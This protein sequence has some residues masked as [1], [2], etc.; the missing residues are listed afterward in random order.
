MADSGIGE[1]AEAGFPADGAGDLIEE[2]GTNFG[3]GGGGA[4]EKISGD[5]HGGRKNFGILKSES[6]SCA[7]GLHEGG[8]VGASDFEGNGSFNAGGLGGGLG[9]GKFL[10]GT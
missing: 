8:V 9:G 2:A 10:G 5:R 3:L 4:S 7:S 6:K 1:L